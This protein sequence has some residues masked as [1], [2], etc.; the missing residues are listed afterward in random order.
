MK[1]AFKGV[2]IIQFM[3][4]VV[5]TLIVISRYGMDLFTP[6]FGDM[7]SLSWAGQFNFDF[8]CYLLLSAI[9]VSWRN[10]FTAKSFLLALIAA[11]FG[12]IFFAPYLLYLA[13]QAEGNMAKVLLGDR[14]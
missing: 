11:V 14:A 1:T 3:A 2:L 9:W 13:I 12:I 8:S 6:F 4:I 5:Y 7:L 10:R